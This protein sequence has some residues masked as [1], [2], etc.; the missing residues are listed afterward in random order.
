MVVVR[1]KR[2]QG[3]TPSFDVGQRAMKSDRL[4]FRRTAVRAGLPFVSFYRRP[5]RVGV[6]TL[7]VPDLCFEVLP[8]DE[9]SG[10]RATATGR[11]CSR[12]TGSGWRWEGGRSGAPRL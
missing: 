6:A 5:E 9:R 2:C 11:P 3:K 7:E 8:L 10:S 4:G 1:R 12:R